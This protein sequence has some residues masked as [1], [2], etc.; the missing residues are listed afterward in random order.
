MFAFP[1]AGVKERDGECNDRET[2]MLQLLEIWKKQ[3]AAGHPAVT[4]STFSRKLGIEAE[5]M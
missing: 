3:W 5:K 2:T 4:R 1:P